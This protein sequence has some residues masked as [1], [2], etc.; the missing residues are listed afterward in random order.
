MPT[1]AEKAKKFREL[2]QRDYAFII[3]NPWD[4]GTARLLQ[5]LGF[6]AWLLARESAW[7]DEYNHER[8]HSSLDDQTP[9]ALRA[10]AVASAAA[11]VKRLRASQTTDSRSVELRELELQLGPPLTAVLAS[12]SE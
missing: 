1:Q 3:P 2:H 5:S 9:V 7:R 10:R 4:V 11:T 12:A 8:P 6:A